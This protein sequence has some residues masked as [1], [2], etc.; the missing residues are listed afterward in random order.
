MD[1]DLQYFGANCF[2]FYNFNTRLVFDD[3]L[4]RFGLKSIS[5]KEDVSFFT[6]YVEDDNLTKLAFSNAGEFE[7]ENVSIKGIQH[8]MFNSD[9]E[10]IIFKLTVFGTDI[11]FTGN[12][13]PNF[14]QKVLE[15]IGTIDILITPC[16]DDNFLIGA[17]NV[18]KLIK[19]LE[20]KLYV[21]SFY[22]INNIKTDFKLLNLDQIIKDLN[23]EVNQK[24]SKIKLKNF[25]IGE[26]LK[27]ELLIL[28]V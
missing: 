17:G 23:L 26:S 19:S 4:N 16:G 10:L 7:I 6:D 9:E 22:L 14:G 13:D 11:L 18:L 24:T 28:E 21:P 1:M 27:T 2:A 20:P 15:E 8:R 5:K 25:E 12:C 3:H